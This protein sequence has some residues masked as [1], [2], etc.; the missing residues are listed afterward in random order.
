MLNSP[1][2]GC[3]AGDVTKV[4][5]EVEG[6]P[7]VPCGLEVSTCSDGNPN[8]SILIIF[9]RGGGLVLGLSSPFRARGVLVPEKAER[10]RA[11]ARI[12]SRETINPRIHTENPI[13]SKTYTGNPTYSSSSSTSKSAL[14]FHFILKI[15][16][17][18]F[19]S[20]K[21]CGVPIKLD[22]LTENISI[23]KFTYTNKQEIKGLEQLSYE[24]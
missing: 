15:F 14:I 23:R 21:I 20:R 2:L 9:V 16:F 6:T 24:G 4:P 19:F 8:A 7:A 12:T 22:I 1:G 18:S 17:H 3:K 10:W 11:P 5:S 13:K